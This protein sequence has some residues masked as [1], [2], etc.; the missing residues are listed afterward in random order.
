MKALDMR[1]AGK[2]A[3]TLKEGM[4][5]VEVVAE[6]LD[7]AKPEW[8]VSDYGD[9]IPWAHTKFVVGPDYGDSLQVSVS[10]GGVVKV[11][12]EPFTPDE[13]RRVNVFLDCVAVS[14]AHY[15]RA[16]KRRMEECK[17]RREK[18]DKLDFPVIITNMEV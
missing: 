14:M 8:K 5:M 15:L 3:K 10:Y 11:E 1:L 13:L 6:A 18:L 2:E 7:F 12:G 17:V 9:G 16:I 4:E